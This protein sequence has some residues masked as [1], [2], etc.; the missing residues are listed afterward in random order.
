MIA[1]NRTL[2]SLLT[3]HTHTRTP[4]VRIITR[5]SVD[6]KEPAVDVRSTIA[7]TTST[8]QHSADRISI[9]SA[10]NDQVVLNSGNSSTIDL[11]D[12]STGQSV[13]WPVRVCLPHAGIRSLQCTL[14]YETVLANPALPHALLGLSA[15]GSVGRGL[16][17]AQLLLQ[18]RRRPP[19][20]HGRNDV[21]AAGAFPCQCSSVTHKDIT[22]LSPFNLS[23]E[24]FST[25]VSQIIQTLSGAIIL[26][27][28]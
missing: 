21:G 7:A 18:Q 14:V 15:A 3:H 12:L 6:I 16:F 27:D 13:L 25:Q 10:S 8:I 19:V 26:D 28:L 5:L 2:S 24:L 11:P 4:Y 1:R 9:V 20:D 22:V 17:A 23:T